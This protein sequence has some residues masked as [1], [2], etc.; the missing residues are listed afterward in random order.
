MNIF[1]CKR[2]VCFELWTCAYDQKRLTRIWSSYFRIHRVVIHWTMAMFMFTTVT[3]HILI[4][5]KHISDVQ[6]SQLYRRMIHNQNCTL[7]M[8]CRLQEVLV[9]SKIHCFTIPINWHV[10]GAYYSESTGICSICLDASP[11]TEFV[12]FNNNLDY[13]VLG[14][15]KSRQ[16]LSF[17]L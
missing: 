11:P 5:L 13:L 2:H 15:L 6:A 4:I 7:L 17:Q 16:V 10:T 8:A 9:R 12:A 14:E 1:Q 3:W